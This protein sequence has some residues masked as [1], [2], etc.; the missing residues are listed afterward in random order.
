MTVRP[1]AAPMD[2]LMF[3]AGAK[4]ARKF[5]LLVGGRI[6]WGESS[7]AEMVFQR[8]EAK[9]YFFNFKKDIFDVAT[10]CRAFCDRNGLAALF[11]AAARWFS[12]EEHECHVP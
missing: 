10:Q 9:R 1:N 8:P 7:A 6:D 4:G 12:R 3:E 2:F 11:D 5:Q